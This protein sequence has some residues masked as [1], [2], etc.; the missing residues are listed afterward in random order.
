MELISNITHNMYQAASVFS[1][2]S[3]GRGD[4][5]VPGN[6]TNEGDT[7]KGKYDIMEQGC[8]TLH[9]ELVALQE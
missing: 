8:S 6:T 7:W 3:T 5:L 9:E 4:V 2:I 1:L